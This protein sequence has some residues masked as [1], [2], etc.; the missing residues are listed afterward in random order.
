MPAAPVVAV[1]GISTKTP[2]SAKSILWPVILALGILKSHV[3][4]SFKAIAYAVLAFQSANASAVS[5]SYLT[6]I[7]PLI[8]YKPP[9][10]YPS[11]SALA[12]CQ[13]TL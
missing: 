11:A 7:D 8:S 10:T 12:P 9:R 5:A 3:D 6:V 2:S 4:P 1:N 13:P